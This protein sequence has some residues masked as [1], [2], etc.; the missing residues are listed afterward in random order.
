MVLQYLLLFVFFYHQFALPFTP[1]TAKTYV[2]FDDQIH[3]TF[4]F[5]CFNLVQQCAHTQRIL[6]FVVW[7][8]TQK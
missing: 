6:A 4:G 2:A 1:N 5:S 7:P 3:V 8:R